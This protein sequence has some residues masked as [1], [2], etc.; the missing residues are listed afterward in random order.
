MESIELYD[1]IIKFIVIILAI[2]GFI[3]TVGSAISYI[4]NWR[5][6]SKTNQNSNIIE[7]HSKAILSLGERV[8]NL[9]KSTSGT[10]EFAKVMCNSMLALLNHNIN[11]NSVDKL[12]KAKEEMEEFLINKE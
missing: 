4:K 1:F 7:E 11:G 10:K 3:T 12:E 8:S 2:A 5:K 6:E 9:E